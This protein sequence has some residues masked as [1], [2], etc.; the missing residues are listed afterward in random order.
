MA[1][2]LICE[3]CNKDISGMPPKKDGSK[4]KVC[5]QQCRTKLC[6]QNMRNARAIRKDTYFYEQV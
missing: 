5:S 2:G 6:M 1:L 4:R 3:I